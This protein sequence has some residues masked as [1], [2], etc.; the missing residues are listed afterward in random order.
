[1]HRDLPR[2]VPDDRHPGRRCARRAAARHRTHRRGSRTGLPGECHHHL[3]VT[4][5][6]AF[7]T[8]EGIFVFSA[9]SRVDNTVRS[10]GI[11]FEYL[12]GDSV[13]DINDA[14]P[15]SDEVGV[16]QT[17][18]FDFQ[19]SSAIRGNT[20]VFY[21]VRAKSLT[22]DNKIDNQY[23]KIYLEK[24]DGDD[25]ST[26]LSPTTFK[27]NPNTSLT[28]ISVDTNTMLLYSGRFSGKKATTTNYSDEFRLKMWLSD[29]YL[30]DDV[31]RSF[32][33]KVLV[34]ASM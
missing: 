31:S 5:S 32:K 9:K 11:T 33:I 6:P 24:K 34:Y 28:N 16:K 15:L 22:V 17:K 8:R 4:P 29:K 12:E 21:E 20:T 18:S 10:G 25:F 3:G 14:L 26:V 19:V 1:M 13:I 7:P 30:I 23:V 27:E 2:G